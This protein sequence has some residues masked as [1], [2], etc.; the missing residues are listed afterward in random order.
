MIFAGIACLRQGKF[1]AAA[2]YFLEVDSAHAAA[3]SEVWNSFSCFLVFRQLVVVIPLTVAVLPAY[4][5][6]SLAQPI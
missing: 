4:S 3:Y 5:L 2:S 1:A 6:A